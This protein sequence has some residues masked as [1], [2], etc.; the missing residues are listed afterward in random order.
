M[1]KSLQGGVTLSQKKRTILIT[2]SV[3]ALLLFGTVLYS[4]YGQ[5][6]SNDFGEEFYYLRKYIFYYLIGGVGAIIVCSLLRYIKIEKKIVLAFIFIAIAL[7]LNLVS[8]EVPFITQVSGEKYASFFYLRLKVTTITLLLLQIAF[9][10]IQQKITRISKYSSFIMNG[11]SILFVMVIAMG[12]DSENTFAAVLLFFA[13]SLWENHGKVWMK[14]VNGFIYCF[15]VGSYYIS[16]LLQ[17]TQNISTW[18]NPYSDEFGKG[19]M[20]VQDFEIMKSAL[21]FGRSSYHGTYSGEIL[22]T[23]LILYGWGMF[24]II[25]GIMVLMLLEMF[26]L[27][28]AGAEGFRKRLMIS[29]TAYFTIKMLFC[30]LV[31]FNLLPFYRGGHLSF[32][33]Y[34]SEVVVDITLLAIFLYRRGSD[35]RSINRINS[36][37]D[38]EKRS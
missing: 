13:L 7:L 35:G 34:G 16:V 3:L 25:L 23:I 37:I 12:E 33:S 17:N 19:Y 24:A 29:I 32:V 28:A 20:K 4:Q 10:L 1:G 15:L 18:L 2:A 36:A 11:I 22:P 27:C 6:V 31:Y 21:I 30:I 26:R 38:N 8:T 5:V 9:L 14:V